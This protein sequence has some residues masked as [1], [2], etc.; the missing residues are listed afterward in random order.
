MIDTSN[1]QCD[2]FEDTHTGYTET[3]RTGVNPLTGDTF[4]YFTCQCGHG[5]ELE[6]FTKYLPTA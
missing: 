5:P 4:T 3:D 1:A 2:S 6:V